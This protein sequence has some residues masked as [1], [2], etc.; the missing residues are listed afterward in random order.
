MAVNH[1]ARDAGSYFANERPEMVAELP[2]PIGR[3]LDV[4]C[5]SGGVGRT[6]RGAGAARIVGIEPHVASANAAREVLDAVHVGTAE[7]VVPRLEERFDAIL[8]YDVLEHTV[9]PAV[10]LD[11]VATVAAPGALVHISVPNARHYSLIRDL[12]L[13]GTF[14]YAEWGHRDTTHLRWFTRRDL[15][16]LVAG[17]GWRVELSVPALLGRT[18]QADRLT[19]GFLREFLALQWHVIGRL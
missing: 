6:L 16:A 10:V 2:R 8:L 1:Q 9:D 4:G 5:G 14:G 15:E 18:A 13:R 3:V 19:L 12:V 7:E 17:R 11:L